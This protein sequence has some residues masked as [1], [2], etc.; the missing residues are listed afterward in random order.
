MLEANKLNSHK[1]SKK[2]FN[3]KLF[4]CEG[5]FIRYLDGPILASLFI[6]FRLFNKPTSTSKHKV[7]LC[8][9]QDS[10]G[11]SLMPQTTLLPAV[12]QSLPNSVAFESFQTILAPCRW[13]GGHHAAHHHADG[14]SRRSTVAMIPQL[15]IVKHE[16]IEPVDVERKKKM[17]EN[18]SIVRILLMEE[19]F[20][21]FFQEIETATLNG[22]W[23]TMQA[24]KTSHYALKY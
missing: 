22:K 12:P 17:G 19:S 11:G 2:V 13:G 24:S 9:C 21:C 15:D 20:L 23:L 18:P 14:S 3:W 6:Y 7:N 5:F 10:N 16:S 8:R 1:I 4:N